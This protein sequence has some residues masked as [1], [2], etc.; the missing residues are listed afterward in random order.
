M[1]K[2]LAALVLVGA[3]LLPVPAAQAATPRFQIR[4]ES[5]HLAQEDPIVAPGVL[6]AHLHEFFGNTTTNANS[7]YE[8]MRAGGTTCSTATDTAGYWVPTL[9]SSDGQI[10]RAR[11]ILLYYRGEEGAH[12]VAFPP[13]LR[14]VSHNSRFGATPS[15]G[16]FTTNFIIK[17]PEC[18]D[19]VH[20]DSP[21][22]IS[23]MAYAT[24]MGCPS[25]HPVRVPAL[26]MV[27]RYPI[28]R[29]FGL[30]LSS[31]PL[32]TMHADFWNTW[33]Q[34]G[35]EALVARCLN[36]QTMS[37]PRIDGEV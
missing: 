36:N 29:L 24:G 10:V 6:S 8:S 28:Q 5:S 34:P 3:L 14:M 31:G 1:R 27:V 21:D 16:A 23:H 11:T 30:T 19:G 20:T 22:H 12:T 32:F 2:L 4:C 26:T 25:S 17:F 35:L 13:D 18:W 15:I 7:T 9:I 37:C 33:D